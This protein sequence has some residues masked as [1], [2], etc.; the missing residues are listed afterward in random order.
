MRTRYQP[1]S[2]IKCSSCRQANS[3]GNGQADSGQGDVVMKSGG[4][5]GCGQGSLVAIGDGQ[6][7]SGQKGFLNLEVMGKGQTDSRHRSLVMISLGRQ[8]VG[9]KLIL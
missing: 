9:T 2:H 1:V 3:I 5:A 4:Q 6:S 7:D 8:T